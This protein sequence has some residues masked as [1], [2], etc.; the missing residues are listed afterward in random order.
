MNS[1]AQIASTTVNGVDVTR[2]QQTIDVIRGNAGL[3]KFQFQID[4]QWQ[5]GPRSRS[6]ARAFFGAGQQHVHA[7]PLQL[8]AD[9][10]PV[11]LGTDTA[12]GAGEL[13]LH[14][15]AAC[16]TG[17]IAY[18]AAARGIAIEKLES[19]VEGDVDLR[20]FLG[21]DPTV[22]NGFS[23]IRMTF[24]IKADVPDAELQALCELGPAFS[25]V[26]DSIS[27]GL[28]VKVVAESLA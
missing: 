10:P 1:I 15:L 22:R 14:A 4:N 20:G 17:T 27:R 5:G 11:L 25:P 28:P 7:R 23:Q 8:T 16:V 18:H 19:T 3:A 13:L 24:R 6:I 26:F 21:L 2:L 9:E 12:A